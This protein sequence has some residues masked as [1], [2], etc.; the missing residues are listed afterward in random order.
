MDAC[1]LVDVSRSM[2]EW[3]P[4]IAA[5]LGCLSKRMPLDARLAVVVYSGTHDVHRLA[6]FTSDHRVVASCLK[7]LRAADDGTPATAQHAALSIVLSPSGLRWRP[8]CGGTV[9]HFTNAMPRSGD[10]TT[11]DPEQLS[12]ERASVL[13]ETGREADWIDIGRAYA[14][15]GVV[16]QPFL[17]K[18]AHFA[19]CV[20]WHAVMAS[21]TSS[22]GAAIASKNARD[23]ENRMAC[24]M[25]GRRPI[26]GSWARLSGEAAERLT[27]T[28]CEANAGRLLTD[29]G[30]VRIDGSDNDARVAIEP[31]FAGLTRSDATN[32]RMRRSL[33]SLE[34]ELRESH[35]WLK[36]DI[37]KILAHTSEERDREEAFDAISASTLRESC[38]EFLET[39]LSGGTLLDMFTATAMLAFG[40]A[41]SAPLSSVQSS[42]SGNKAYNFQTA[43]GVVVRAVRPGYQTSYGR[44]LEYLESKRSGKW[45]RSTLP[46]LREGVDDLVIRSDGQITGI[47]PVVADDGDLAARV[48]AAMARTPWLNAI[49][50]HSVCR[51]VVYPPHACV[52]LLG[53]SL[54]SGCLDDAVQDSTLARIAKS[55]RCFQEPLASGDDL[56]RAV[57]RAVN[58]GGDCAELLR[59]GSSYARRLSVC[60]EEAVLKALNRLRRITGL[61][62]VFYYPVTHRTTKK[63]R[64][65]SSVAHC[66]TSD[67]LPQMGTK[68]FNRALV[69]ALHDSRRVKGLPMTGNSLETFEMSASDLADHSSSSGRA[70]VAKHGTAVFRFESTGNWLA[71]RLGRMRRYPENRGGRIVHVWRD[72]QDATTS[73]PFCLDASGQSTF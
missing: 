8:Q 62:P 48:Y 68:R 57:I 6:D 56:P 51:H 35:A 3:I 24:M 73:S 21:L 29:L 31:A 61:E 1:A 60:A 22:D 28:S 72:D 37:G 41:I 20:C 71:V 55:V 14:R 4:T 36:I 18:G 59:A 54:W 7:R 47:L 58:R 10:V 2:A 15:S 63:P 46:D 69:D 19:A 70:L 44:F 32:K 26:S 45:T 42:F 33:Y 25:D 13:R 39:D 27:E 9:F 50:W 5:A 43:F 52:G 64:Q 40:P 66:P 30:S 53:A 17:F 12:A 49:A 67:G 65:S 23:I 11:T 38:V 34:E 16:V